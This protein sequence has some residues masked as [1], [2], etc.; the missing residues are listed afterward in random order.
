MTV[1]TEASAFFAIA[2]YRGVEFAQLLYGGDDVSGEEWN[3]RG[4]NKLHD[5]RH[6]MFEIATEACL[7]D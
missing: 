4:W 2:K 7:Q 5:L 3:A 6:K 1:D